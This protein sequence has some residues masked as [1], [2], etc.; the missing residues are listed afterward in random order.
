MQRV[1]FDGPGRLKIF[2][3]TLRHNQVDKFTDDEAAQLAAH[4]HIQVTVLGVTVH[5]A[6]APSTQDHEEKE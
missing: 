4:P 6:A 5:G 2:G 3:K 1:R